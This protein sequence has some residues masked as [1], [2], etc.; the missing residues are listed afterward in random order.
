MTDYPIEQIPISLLL[1]K[2]LHSRYTREPV[3]A[4]MDWVDSMKKRLYGMADD[5]TYF[6]DS[7][8]DASLI[9]IY[10]S[11]YREG[12]KHPLVVKKEN[13]GFYYVIVGNQRLICLNAMNFKGYVPCMVAKP[14][15]SWED[16][17][18]ASTELKMESLRRRLNEM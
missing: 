7:S 2:I 13:N 3:A 5:A 1:Y 14:E 18:L 9:G 11:L 8:R 15:D 12:L 4:Y 17:T 10:R 6:P 16:D